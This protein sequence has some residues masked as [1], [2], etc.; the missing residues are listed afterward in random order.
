MAKLKADPITDRD[1]ARFVADDSDFAFEMK[2]LTEL[3]NL[4][5][6]CSHSGTYRDPITSKIRQFDI[7]A[8][9]REGA[10][11]LALA[12]ECK[13][14]R[15]N[16]PLLVS[17]VPRVKAEAF[18]NVVVY[19]DSVVNPAAVKTVQGTD[20]I[21]TEGEMVGKKTD[22]VGRE[23]PS[24]DL[25]S[26]D[27]T[28]FEKLNQALN[29]SKDLVD[30]AVYDR[31]PHDVRA[32][33]PALLV[34]QGTLWQVDYA[35][36]GGMLVPPRNVTRATIFIDHTWSVKAAFG[37]QDY[38][39]SHLEVITLDALRTTVDYWFGESGFFRAFRK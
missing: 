26:D 9:K 39:L 21:Y 1:L 30:D 2:V 20:S 37:P 5:F 12:V 18:H 31:P 14:L 33:V 4:G 13:N 27:S 36:G 38:H 8:L 22:Q 29:S 10:L 7:R 3:R 24:G 17:A 35:A 34:P 28:T 16:H 23:L 19:Q 15:T 32:V 11:M 25:I 6:D